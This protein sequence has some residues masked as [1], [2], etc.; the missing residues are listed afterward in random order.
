ML[1]VVTLGVVCILMVVE[2]ERSRRNDA[3]L[4]ARGATEPTGDV[5]RLMQWAYPGV[6][7]LMA[8]EGLTA[9][10]PPPAV[11]IGGIVL[12]IAAKALKYWAIAS[13]GDRWTFRVLVPPAGSLVAHGPYAYV[14]HPNYIAVLGEIVAVAV[15]V[16]A[17]VTGPLSL[18]FFAELIRRRIRVE[19]AA[20]RHPPCSSARP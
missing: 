17:R 3:L 5:Y 20:L 15:I 18:F 4:R 19:N 6:F 9:G 10:T 1:S 8:A 2:L 14:Q 13:L 12:F 11:S 7:V 16:G